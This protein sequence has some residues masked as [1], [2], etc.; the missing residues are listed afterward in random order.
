MQ[1]WQND[2]VEGET[3]SLGEKPIKL[4]FFPSQFY[5]DWPRIGCRFL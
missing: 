3:E 5:L 2:S 1:L 4:P